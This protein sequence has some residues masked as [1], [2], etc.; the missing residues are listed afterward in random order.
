MDKYIDIPDAAGRY[1]AGESTVR[2]WIKYLRMP[3]IRAGRVIRIK[4][5]DADRWYEAGGPNG[6]PEALRRAAENRAAAKQAPSPQV[7]AGRQVAV[8]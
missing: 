8:G 6:L 1:R 7:S 5:E 4:V 3:V 2:A